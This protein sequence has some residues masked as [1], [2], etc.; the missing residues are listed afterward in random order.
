MS[1]SFRDAMPV[2]QRWA[3]LDHAAVAPLPLVAQE[4]IAEWSREAAEQGDVAWPRW[5]QAVEAVRT[6]AAKLVNAR[7]DEIGLVPSTTAG[8]SLVAD[9]FPWREGDNVVT[10]ENEFPSNLYPWL[11]L[12]RRGVETRKVRVER[13]RVDLDR[14]AQACDSRTRLVSAS[15]VGYASGWRLDVAALAELVH[16]RHAL[17][18][19]DAIQGLGVFPLDVQAAG[20]DF[21]AADGHK[22]MLG[23]EGAGIVYIRH[24]LLGMLQ[25][26]GVG[27]HSAERPYDFSSRPLVLR[28]QA[29]RYEGGTRNTAGF[30]ALGASLELLEQQGYSTHHSRIAERILELAAEAAHRIVAAGGRL[31]YDRQPGCDSGIVTFAWPG[32][33][34]AELRKRCLQAGVVLSCRG[35]G[36]R[37]SFHGYNNED[38]LERLLNA[39]P[40]LQ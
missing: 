10:L 34:P 8:I 27:W 25:P 36:V 7:S 15:W 38:D 5:N 3:Y 40:R 2:S 37:M 14:I 13:G 12:A 31:C 17:L 26:L 19:L 20:V 9:G 11:N 39:L 28:D 32:H 23:P 21:A 18:M 33:D 30:L 24:E 16:D 29:A 6:R 22:W 35:G 1:T 4:A